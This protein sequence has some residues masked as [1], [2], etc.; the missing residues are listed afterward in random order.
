[1]ALRR[2]AHSAQLDSERL[3]RTFFSELFRADCI[4]P[5]A[6]LEG[7]KGL[8][9]HKRLPPTCHSLNALSRSFGRAT[10]MSE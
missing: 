4:Q 2:S 8:S 3:R 10:A 9:R 1:M 6:M 5:T 7:L